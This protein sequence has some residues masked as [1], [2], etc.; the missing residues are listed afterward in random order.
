MGKRFSRYKLA[1]KLA[2]GRGEANSA[3]ARYVD[4]AEGKTRLNYP[5]AASSKHEGIVS[6]YLNSF[7]NPGTATQFGKATMSLRAQNN[8]NNLIDVVSKFNHQTF[9]EGTDT[10]ILEGNWEPAKAVIRTGG[11]GTTPETSQITGEPYTKKT[12]A[13]SYTIPF[14]NDAGGNFYD[15]A[16][17]INTGVT[18]QNADHTVSFTPE[19]IMG[20]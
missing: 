18:A 11:T 7:L 4:Y 3:L 8:L 12:G 16:S 17:E 10:V 2:G 5:R 1:K 19:R 9:T 6:V 13:Q 15:I 14:G 20:L